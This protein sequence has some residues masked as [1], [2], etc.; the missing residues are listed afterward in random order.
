MYSIAYMKMLKL[1]EK[2]IN[3]SSLP[4]LLPEETNYSS[5]K[6]ETITKLKLNTVLELI[7]KKF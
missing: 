1:F 5:P 4:L 3:S 7:F 2:S 6:R